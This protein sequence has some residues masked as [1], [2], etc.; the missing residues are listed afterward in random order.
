LRNLSYSFL[1][2]KKDSD[3]GRSKNALGLNENSPKNEI[4][5]AH[6]TQPNTSSSLGDNSAESIL[7]FFSYAVLVLGLIGSIIIGIV[8]GDDNEALGWGCFFG[9]VVSVII[10]WA[11][12][13]VIINISNNIRQ[14]KK[15]LQGRI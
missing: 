12:C 1:I 5:N 15:H 9:G 13:M 14:I 3:N 6:S 2:L 10:T 4:S 8:V 7:T 11:V